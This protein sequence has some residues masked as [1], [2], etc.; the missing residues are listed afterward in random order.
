VAVLDTHPAGTRST[1]A[2]GAADMNLAELTEIPADRLA[3]LEREAGLDRLEEL[4]AAL[5]RSW[6]RLERDMERDDDDD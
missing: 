2:E 6:R 3:E 4:G 1:P 5:V